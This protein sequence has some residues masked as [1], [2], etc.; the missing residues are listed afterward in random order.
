M[1]NKIKKILTYL[2]KVPLYVSVPITFLLIAFIYYLSNYDTPKPIEVN[3]TAFMEMIENEEVKE[4]K[5]DLNASSLTFVDHQDVLYKTPNPRA[6]DFKQ[7]LLEQGLLVE[8]P[9]KLGNSIRN[10]I[11]MVL[12]ILLF[13]GLLVYLQKTSATGNFKFH[14]EPEFPTT[15]FGDIA[16]NEEAKKDL[17]HKIHSL[18]EP[19]SY[20]SVGAT[21]PK[22]I[23]LTGPPGTG[24]TLMA[25]ALAGESKIPLFSLS[26]SDFVEIYVGVGAKRIRELF[27]KA[28]EHAPCIIFIDELDAIGG[29]RSMDGGGGESEREQTLNALL[30]EMTKTNNLLVIGATN[31][32]DMLDAALIRPGRFDNKVTMNNPNKEDRLKIIRKHLENK[33]ISSCVSVTYLAKKTFGLSGADIASL[34]NEAAILCARG[35]REVLEKKDFDSALIKI[36]TK[37][38]SVTTKQDERERTITAWHEAG[39]ALVTRLLTTKEITEVS[40]VP[41]TSGVG[42]YTMS[43]SDKENF[44][45]KSEIIKEIQILYAGRA[46]EEIEAKDAELVTTGASNDIL[47]AT[48]LIKNTISKYGMGERGLIDST[49]FTD[50]ETQLIEEAVKLSRKLYKETLLLLYKNKELLEK[51]AH[52]LLEKEVLTTEDLE[53]IFQDLEK[54]A[55]TK[56]IENILL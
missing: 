29:S 43:H 35:N 28:R 51:I 32:E 55:T 49:Q 2:N 21:V 54:V 27:K 38:Y 14:L 46:A 17:L 9:S 25:Q 53:K 16:G 4:V 24:K 18:V 33:K 19:S 47:R 56:E 12:Q 20:L 42:G 3:Y 52:Q 40:I 23:L 13:V 45:T 48:A 1:K 5:L 6:Q 22:G 36:I 41:T 10:S 15:T 44:I 7:S 39:H 37:G 31:R 11:V 26:G 50:G 30:V 8:E 34:I